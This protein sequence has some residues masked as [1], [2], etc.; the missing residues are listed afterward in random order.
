MESRRPVI[1]GGGV[2]VV[3]CGTATLGN[4]GAKMRIE[5]LLSGY[6]CLEGAKGEYLFGKRGFSLYTALD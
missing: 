6:R 1:S 4:L 5:L 3:V 2:G